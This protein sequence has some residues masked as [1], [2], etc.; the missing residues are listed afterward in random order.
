MFRVKEMVKKIKG[1]KKPHKK[2]W[3]SWS[4]QKEK[5]HNRKQTSHPRER[6]IWWCSIGVNI[7][8]EVDGKGKD[9]ARP[10]LILKRVSPT[11]FFCVPLTKQVK[12]LPGYYHYDNTC[13]IFEQ[14]RVINIKRMLKRERKVDAKSFK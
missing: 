1:D 11:N 2:Q 13:I 3:R 14:A 12:N 10:V 4:A 5:L 6:E 9:F 8:N 7:G